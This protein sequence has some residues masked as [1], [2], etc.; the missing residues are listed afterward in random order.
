[1]GAHRALDGGDFLSVRAQDLD[2]VPDR[3]DD[4]AAIPHHVQFERRR[5]GPDR[6]QSE[7]HTSGLHVFELRIVGWGGGPRRMEEFAAPVESET[8]DG[9]T[10]AGSNRANEATKDLRRHEA[11]VGR[12]CHRLP[13]TK[14]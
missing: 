10:L 8:H 3:V 12:F 5:K 11:G 13:F 7:E 4:D 1:M 9:S 6:S 2:P 14:I